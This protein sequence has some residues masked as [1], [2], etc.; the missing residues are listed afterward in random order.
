MIKTTMVDHADDNN[1]NEEEIFVYTGGRAPRHVKHVRIDASVTVIDAYAFF[2]NVNLLRVDMHNKITK[3]GSRAFRG[4]SLLRG[5]KLVGV[6]SLEREAFY[7]CISLGEVEFGNELETIKEYA[8]FGCYSIQY[9]NIPSVLS[10][11]RGAFQKCTSITDAELSGD[12]ESIGESAFRSCRALTRIAIPFNVEMIL[13][14]SNLFDHCENLERVDIIGE[15][16][17]TIASLHLESW[18]SSIFEVINHINIILPLTHHS[19]KTEEVQSW[20]QQVKNTIVQY[21]SSHNMLLKEATTLLELAVWK[22]K[23]DHKVE[24]E[25]PSREPKTK[26]ARI[27]KDSA[28]Q[29]LRITSG[30]NTVIKNVIPFLK[31]T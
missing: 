20:I 2:R 21:K 12:L 3:V 1:D 25:D 8:F 24:R 16:E 5:I 30:A 7:D 13:E 9:L 17:R 22:S 26:K 28:R 18:R 14:Y 31:L 27:D 29:G 4:C 19:R 11:E 15:I 6:K 23:I 10:I